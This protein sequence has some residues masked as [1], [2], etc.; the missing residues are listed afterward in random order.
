[1][2]E[3]IKAV[4]DRNDL[5]MTAVLGQPAAL[6]SELYAFGARRLQANAE[7]FKEWTEARAPS[8]Y[9]DCEIRFAARAFEAYADEALRL[10]AIVSA[11]AAD[12]ARET[13]PAPAEKAN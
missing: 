5:P 4:A 6:A 7:R 9:I 1:M 11:R 12:A 3:E 10:Q 13:A 8:D 2:P